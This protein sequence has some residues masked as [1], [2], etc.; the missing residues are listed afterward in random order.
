M[1]FAHTSTRALTTGHG[2]AQPSGPPSET[3]HTSFW[4][5]RARHTRSRACR[6]ER[7]LVFVLASSVATTLAT[8]LF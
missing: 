7:A 1:P 4:I 3:L 2:G 8:L 6:Y 5:V